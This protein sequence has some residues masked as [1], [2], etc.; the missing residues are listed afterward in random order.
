MSEAK[1]TKG[2]WEVE[3]GC[4]QAFVA[5]E[6]KFIHESNVD[7]ATGNRNERIANAHLIAAAPEMYEFI[8]THM[9]GHPEA[10]EI[11]AKARGEQND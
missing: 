5:T 11:L 8:E 6:N 7:I 2:E 9:G 10:E 4:S 3:I 1:F